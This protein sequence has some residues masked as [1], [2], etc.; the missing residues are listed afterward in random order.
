LFL[1]KFFMNQFFGWK[2]ALWLDNV[3]KIC[4][5]EAVITRK[6]SRKIY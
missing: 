2:K 5:I 1:G 4:Q 3:Q 6:K